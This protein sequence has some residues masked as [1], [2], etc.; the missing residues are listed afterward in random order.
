MF[1]NLKIGSRLMIGF[2]IMAILVGV[3]SFFSIIELSKIQKPLTKDI[4]QG[5]RDI[6][7]TSRLDSLAQRV[8]YYGQ[9]LTESVKNYALTSDKKWKYRYLNIEPTLESVIQ[10]AINRGDEEDKRIFSEIQ[11]AKRAFVELEKSSIDAV[12]QLDLTKARLI[13]EGV[14]YWQLKE[15]YKAGEEKY[16]TR[17]GKKLGDTLEVTSSNV[18]LMVEQTNRLVQN[19]IRLLMTVSIFGILLAMG[20]GFLVANSILN[21]IKKLQKGVQIIGK[22]NLEHKIRIQSKDEI[23]QFAAAF[24][25]MTLKLKE[26][27]TGLEEK[28]NEKTKELANKIE[29]IAQQNQELE[30]SRKTI[31][32]VLHDLEIAKARIEKEKVESEALLASIGD[33]I[34]ATDQNGK[35]RMINHQVEIMLGWKSEEAIG[36]LFS[37]IIAS[38]DEKGNPI[39]RDQRPIPTALATGNKITTAAYYVRK[40]RTKFPVSITVSPI[41][42]DNEIV[43]AIEIVRDITKEKE[44][45]R[46]KTEFI[47]TVSHELR[48]P[49]TVIREGVSLV[50]DGILGEVNAKQKKFLGIA[51]N[52]ID[53][54][55]RIIDNLL[56]I[57]KIE[58]GKV[59]IKRDEVDMVELAEG[60]ISNFQIQAKNKGLEL[61]GRFPHRPILVY[62]DPDRIVQVLTNLVGNALKFTEK[63][64]IEISVEDKGENVEAYVA[65]TGKGIGQE[66]LQKVFGKFQQFDR[67]DGAGE[68]GTGLGLSIAKGI[69]ELHH[70]KI[71]VE[72][73]LAHGSKFTFVLPKYNPQEF[74]KNYIAEG[75]RDAKQQMGSFSM[76]NFHIE[77]FEELKKELGRE[78]IAVLLNRLEGLAKSSLRRQLDSVLRYA[79]TFFI[80]LPGTEKRHAESIAERI[81]KCF[82]DYLSKEEFGRKV[83]IGCKIAGYPEDGNSEA[84]LLERAA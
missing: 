57:S 20:L 71:W 67:T 35:I 42:L 28:V 36:K 15:S 14:T 73:E 63:G 26:S 82:A 69:V 45:D 33:G 1:K 27:Y 30:E 3:V 31:L 16:V 54:L 12:D 6:E 18:D 23:G 38:Q 65:D 50:I 64:W 39:P 53:R 22:G 76:I 61:R 46:M 40:D 37:D 2:M 11:K 51:L 43:G 24:N 4:P 62:V 58:A 13:L 81:E 56:N 7:K 10:E 80:I 84:T 77:G 5:L 70:G 59:E 72:S 49:L 41:K 32:E 79:H 29:E 60:V 8:Q 75:L 66:D 21:P 78:K 19:S 47:S 55:K 17:R 48:T 25:E 9:L 52:D 68:K 74:L 44:V 34:I 83:K